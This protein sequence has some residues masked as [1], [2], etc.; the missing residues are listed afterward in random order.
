MLRLQEFRA[1][2]NGL[3]PAP[4]VSTSVCLKESS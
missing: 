4:S 2:S 3:V 1:D